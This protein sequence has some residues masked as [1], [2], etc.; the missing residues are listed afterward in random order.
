MQFYSGT[1][2]GYRE[3]LDK[4]VECHIDLETDLSAT[5]EAV[6]RHRDQGLR[7]EKKYN[8][9]VRMVSAL[10][11][12]DATADQLKTLAHMWVCKCQKCVYYSSQD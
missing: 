6:D 8:T 1:I 2:P 11:V 5:K 9:I 3:F 4:H 12:V 10:D 7:L